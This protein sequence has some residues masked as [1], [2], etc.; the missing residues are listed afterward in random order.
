VAHSGT[1][2]GGEVR[3]PGFD[4]L[5]QAGEWDAVTTGV[6][7]VR[8][9]PPPPL[10]FFTVEEE[11][12]A[13]PLLDR[14]LAQTAEPRIPVFEMIDAR[15]ADGEID[16]W[17]HEDMPE[18][19]AAWQRSLA[20]L[21][22]DARR[23]GAGR[24]ADLAGSEQDDLLEEIRTGKDWH[25]LPAA[26]LW[27]LWMRYACAAFYSHP[28]AWNEI[29]F[30]GPAYPRGYKALGLDHREPWERPEVDA[31]DPEPWSHRVERSRRGHS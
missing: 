1:T 17:R 2:P 23:L 18:D 24:F 14:L 16:G 4:V 12:A 7:L 26:R 6:V 19:G 29:G 5:G 27:N 28:W 15:L 21:D 3:F 11:A 13:R 22:D 25:G 30:G 8:L 20:G 9:A 31:L 10:R